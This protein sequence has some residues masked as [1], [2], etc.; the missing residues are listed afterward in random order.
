M[1]TITLCTVACSRRHHRVPLEAAVAELRDRG[2]P[3]RTEPL[4]VGV[5]HP[6]ARDDPGA[7]LRA[8][9]VLVEIDDGID[10]VGRDQA[11]LDEER[12]ERGRADG[13]VVVLVAHAAPGTSR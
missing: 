1:Q 9:V 2:R 6:G 13:H 5:V 7:V 11:L 8:D 4:A 3:V 10:R 12:L